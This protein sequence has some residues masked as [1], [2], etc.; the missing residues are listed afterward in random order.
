MFSL[1][2]IDRPLCFTDS[3]ERLHVSAGV[4]G[5]WGLADSNGLHIRAVWSVSGTERPAEGH[6]WAWIF[7]STHPDLHGE[8]WGEHPKGIV[9]WISSR[10]GKLQWCI[11]TILWYVH[12]LWEKIN[13]W[14]YLL[15]SQI[16]TISLSN[17]GCCNPYIHYIIIKGQI[18][19]L[20]M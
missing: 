3:T 19:P 16:G 14:S 20:K 2:Q 4:S 7:H 10:T 8:L 9:K 15:Q 11:N 17:V 12:I 6:F 13:V 1:L 18:G 5:P